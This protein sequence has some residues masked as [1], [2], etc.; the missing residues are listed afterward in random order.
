[1]AS[2]T[3]GAHSRSR[4]GIGRE[5]LDL[6]RLGRVRQIA[7][8]VLQNLHE[9]DLDGR[10]FTRDTF[11]ELRDDFVDVTAALALQLD[12]NV[13]AVGLGD[14]GQA[15]L[16]AGA[17]R[18]A[19]DFR[20]FAQHLLDVANNAV[21]LSQRGTRRHPVIEDEATLVHLGQQVGAQRLITE[22]GRHHQHQAE[23]GNP[24]RTFQRKAHPMLIEI[25]QASEAARQRRVL[26]NEQFF[27][28]VKLRVCGHFNILA[29]DE[30]LAE[31]RRPGKSKGQR[32]EQRHADRDGQ[33]AE[34]HAGHARNCNQREKHDDGRNRGADQ[35]RGN[36]AQ[37]AADGLD[38]ALS[39]VAMQGDVL[40]HHDGIINH[41]P[42]RGC[43]S[44]QR[45]QVESLVEHLEGD[46]GHQHRDRNH[47]ARHQRTSPVVQK[48]H[49]DERGE[50]QA[51]QD[52]VAHAGDGSGD[53][54]RLIVERLN[55]DSRR[56]RRANVLDLG[57]HLIGYLD[58]VGVGLAV[59]AQQNRGLAVR[60]D[61]GINR[62]HRVCD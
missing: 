35:R 59:D 56:Q 52:R 2:A 1:M 25:N 51:N 9:L 47:Q 26:G 7:D 10:L 60:G 45:H 48:Q 14:G 11:A 49:H 57:V 23:Q 3:R 20:D 50:N 40:H 16:Q 22:E 8:H 36:L 21:G 39:G 54:L 62:L 12:G 46:E 28:R 41:Q 29:P 61:H 58:R 5:Q 33:R 42:D 30:V 34:E 19:F 38:P 13:A 15:Q 53:D 17:A 43:Q 24:P 27:F 32:S 31:R 37:R 55:M 6:H 44:T 18:R 4:R